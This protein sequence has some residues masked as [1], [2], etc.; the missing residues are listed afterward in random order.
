[1]TGLN[2]FRAFKTL[3]EVVED[4]CNVLT[5]TTDELVSHVENMQAEIKGLGRKIDELKLNNLAAAIDESVKKEILS[6]ER[7]FSGSFKG[8]F[9]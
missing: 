3:L 5:L 4:L 8:C 7:P 1:M 2:A 9:S 6:T